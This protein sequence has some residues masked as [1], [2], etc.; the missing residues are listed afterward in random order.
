VQFTLFDAIGDTAWTVI[1]TLLG[2]FV[3]RK[4]PNVDHYFL[5]AVLAAMLFTFAP[6][7]YH[8]VTDKKFHA[9]LRNRFGKHA[10][11][12]DKE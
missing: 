5:L 7:L 3:G 10:V 9:K 11:R 4:I 2:Y 12:N 1:V 8:L 6:L